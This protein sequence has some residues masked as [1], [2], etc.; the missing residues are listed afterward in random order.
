MQRAAQSF[1]QKFSTMFFNKKL[2]IYNNLQTFPQSDIWAVREV[3]K[4]FPQI[5][6]NFLTFGLFWA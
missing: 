4:S 5:V 6:N 3:L 2:P 1:P